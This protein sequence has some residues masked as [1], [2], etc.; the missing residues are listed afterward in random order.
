MS[1]VTYSQSSWL[2]T[3]CKRMLSVAWNTQDSLF[4]RPWPLS[5]YIA[6]GTISSHLWWKMMWDNMRKRMYVYIY[7]WLGHFAIQQKLTEYCKSTIIE[8]IK[9]LFK[10]EDYTFRLKI[11]TMENNMFCWRFIGIS[12]GVTLPTWT[13]TRTKDFYTKKFATTNHTPHSPP[14]FM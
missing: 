7:V 1:S 4:S 2:C 13:A 10:K 12:W 8:R 5:C 14:L 9:I 11:C 3:F 6:Q